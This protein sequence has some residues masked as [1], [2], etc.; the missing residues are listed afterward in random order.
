MNG[1]ATGALVTTVKERCRLCYTCVRECPAKAIRVVHGQ[2]EIIPERCIACGNCVRVCSRQAKQVRDTTRDVRRLLNG[3]GPVAACIAPS[4]PAS[5]PEFDHRKLVAMVRALGFHYVNEVAF[6]AELVARRYGQLVNGNGHRYITANCPAVVGFVERFHPNLTEA[7]A[8]VVSPMVATARVLRALHGPGL[9]IVFF[10]PCIAKKLEAADEDVA[11]D[12]DA[13]STFVGLR[14]LFD[15]LGVTPSDVDVSGFDPPHAFLGGIAPV[16][17][18]ILQVAG[19][20]EDLAKGDV[21]VATGRESFVEALKEFESGS[22]DTALLDLLACKGC[23]MGPGMTADGPFFLRRSHLG[24]YLRHVHEHRDET[25]CL[26]DVERFAGLDLSRGFRENDQRIP[27]PSEEELVE[28]LEQMGKKDASDELNCGAC[29]Y[30][31]CREHA[32]AIHKGLAETGMCLPHTINELKEAIGELAGLNERPVDGEQRRAHDETASLAGQF[33][34][35]LAHE[36]SNPLGVILMYIHLLLEG[37]NVS[38]AMARDLTK[39]A[40]QAGRCKQLV[41]DVIHFTRHVPLHVEPVDIRALVSASIRASCVPPGVQLE[42]RHHAD[43]PMLDVDRA[44]MVQVLRILITNACE[45]MPDGGILTV[46]TR[47]D[48]DGQFLLRV[49]DTGEGIAED[50]VSRLFTPFFTTKPKGHGTGLG[51]A[52]ARRIVEMH[53]G[54]I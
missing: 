7:L 1:A 10:G 37:S 33:A 25:R 40:E 11:G 24:R 3:D 49:I 20:T 5:F 53:S 32:T 23:I 13:A 44:Q 43:E 8:P 2:A 34:A 4:F 9:R 15:D 50:N 45:A 21:V 39:A 31:T 47:H 17:R 46:E 30:P 6:G 27:A 54:A 42:V 35:G 29:G 38:P 28:I 14:I 36:L 16:S 48:G 41:T 26:A 12:V 19:I 22:L 52:T 51:L 18:G